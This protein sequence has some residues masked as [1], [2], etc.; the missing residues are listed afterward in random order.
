MKIY[1]ASKF[2]NQDAFRALKE[3]LE[4][5]GHKITHDWTR[6]EVFAN[7]RT[8]KQDLAMFANLDF[9]GVTS[10]DAL[11]LLAAPKMAGAFVEL[12][13]ALALGKMI[14][15]VDG[16]KEG[17]PP[18]IFYNLPFIHHVRRDQVLSWLPAVPTTLAT[19]Y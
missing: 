5:A 11:V 4:Q 18:C 2:E 9:N 12:G 8:L 17:N 3:E 19:C 1:I 13:I 6:E 10:C 14:L 7:S 15:V 16:Y